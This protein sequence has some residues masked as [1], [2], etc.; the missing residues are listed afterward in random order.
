M[1][2]Q[3]KFLLKMNIISFRNYHVKF[4]NK[5][6]QNKTKKHVVLNIYQSQKY[7]V[8]LRKGFQEIHKY[9]VKQLSIYDDKTNKKLHWSR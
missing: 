7:R 2:K 1:G 9:L 3:Q 4:K 6:K 5:T 8:T